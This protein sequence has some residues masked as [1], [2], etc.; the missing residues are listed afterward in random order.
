MTIRT[1]QNLPTSEFKIVKYLSQA[2][3]KYERLER[4]RDDLLDSVETLVV[5][6]SL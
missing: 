1:R 3:T 5:S 4:R 2:K 6:K